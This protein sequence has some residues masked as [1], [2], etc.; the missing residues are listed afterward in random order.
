VHGLD[1]KDCALPL[2]S[3]N[4]VD[5]REEAEIEA[6]VKKIGGRV[7]A[8]FSCAGLPQTFASLDVMK[9]NFLA[10]RKLAELVVPLMPKGGAIATIASTAGLGWSQRLPTVMELVSTKSFAEGLK[11]CEANPVAV[12]EGYGFSKEAVIVWTMMAS[13]QLIQKGIRI[14]CT[15]PG[16]TQTPMMPAFESAAPLAVIDFAARPINRRATPAERAG[17]LVFLNGDAA[18]YVNGVPFPVDGGFTGGIS[19]GQFSMADM[20]AAARAG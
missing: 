10:A 19:T 15:L 4:K 12:S 14:N 6:V 5:L 16:P 7:D 18:S 9:V 13:S 3:F 2:A 20:M 1:Y 17:L 11:W 8:L